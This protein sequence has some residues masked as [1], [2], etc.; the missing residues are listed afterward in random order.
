[1]TGERKPLGLYVAA[2][3]FL[4][5]IIS[6]VG[7]SFMRPKPFS[8]P[9]TPIQP[10]PDR[11]GFVIDTITV[12]ARDGSQWIFFN[13]DMGSVVEDPPSDGWDLAI[14]RFHIVTNGGADYAG[15]GGAVAL[16]LPWD[17]VT[18]AP[19]NGYTMTAGRLGDS[20]PAANPALER[21]YEYSFFAHTLD[22]KKETYVIR[23]AG[24]HYAKL[25]IVSY[26]CPEAT[27][28]CMTIAYGYQNDGT[29]RLTP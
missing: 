27:P 8:F 18:E 7:A 5:V 11:E 14:N 16:A 12:D 10:Q 6:V 21:W 3:V 1:M 25:R 17:S 23:T 24:G 28:G 26:Y 15:Q 19:R 2:V 29:H 9:P 22:P 20:A 4:L 13:F